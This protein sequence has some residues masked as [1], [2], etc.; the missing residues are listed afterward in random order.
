MSWF[1][2]RKIDPPEVTSTGGERSEKAVKESEKKLEQ[3]KKAQDEVL[4]VVKRSRELNTHKD[5]FAEALERA[6]RRDR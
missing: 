5:Y 1:R 4:K 2:R 6:M 3:A